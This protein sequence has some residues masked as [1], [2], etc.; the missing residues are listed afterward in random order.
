MRLLVL[1][2]LFLYAVVT[3]SQSVTSDNNISN[4]SPVPDTGSQLIA[5]LETDRVSA[6]VNEQILLT[7]TVSAPSFAFNI[8]GGKL[9]IDDVELLPLNRQ[10]SEFEVNNVPHQSEKTIFAIFPRIAGTVTIPALSFKAVL[11]VSASRPSTSK[12]NPTLNASTK[13]FQINVKPVP[14]SAADWLPAQN[15]AASSIW[16][17]DTANS[18][19][20]RAGEP[21]TRHVS[22]TIDG[23]HPGAI[24]LPEINTP[25]GIRMYPDL[26]RIET[27]TIASGINGTLTLSSAYVFSQIGV[28]Q[29]PAIDIRWW[30][31][32]RQRFR[33]TTIPGEQVNVSRGEYS[34]DLRNQFFKKHGHLI[35]LGL[36]V[37]VILL[38][39][40]CIALLKKIRSFSTAGKSEDSK[41]I[42]SEKTAWST[43]QKAIR[44]KDYPLIRQSLL[45][46]G[47]R[48]WSTTDVRRLEQLA[49]YDDRMSP[50]SRELD[51][52]LYSENT[53]SAPN[54][55]ALKHMLRDVR[56]SGRKTPAT[57][58]QLELLYPD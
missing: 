52:Y 57:S 6:Y 36:L 13:A 50:V 37:L 10:A 39:G 43:L 16:S 30:D 45:V 55:R 20:I 49:Q 12:G 44:N 56:S 25:E 17:V 31:I 1:T 29:L 33:T 54:L 19:S 11:P 42:P 47:S 15:L 38:S 48:L 14:D 9:A 40:S 22:I 46:W 58:H 28:A 4:Q 5:T 34:D 32:N 27:Q 24:P 41:E 53:G 23:Q 2:T 7:L 3:H 51:E 35:L 8:T 21:V 26:P 18:D